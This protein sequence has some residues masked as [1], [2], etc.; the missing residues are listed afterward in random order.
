MAEVTLRGLAHD[1]RWLIVEPSGQFLT[2]RTQP[3]LALVRPQV[4]VDGG[5]R[6]SAP[7]QPDLVVAQPTD[8]ALPRR[9]QV[10]S[11]TVDAV[12]ADAEAH[13]WFSAYLHLDVQLVYMP[14]ERIRPADPAYGNPGDHVSFA[15]G[16]PILITTEASLADLNRRLETPVPMNRFRPNIVVNGTEP[17]AEDQWKHIQIGELPM[18]SVKSCARC[19]VT[20][21]DQQ[22]AARGKEPLRT[23]ATFRKWDGGVYFGQNLIPDTTG[24]IRVGDAI[25]TQIT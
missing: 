1:R 19:V 14:A 25:S 5:L 6:L 7:G 9:V 12:E 17:F 23:L 22:T 18:R 11:D 13:A 20:T 8:T 4:L 2:Q 16:Y 3:T 10:W 21:T 24:I 15:D